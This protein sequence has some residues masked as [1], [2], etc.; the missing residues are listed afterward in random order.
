MKMKL[1]KPAKII[2]A[3]IIFMAAAQVIHTLSGFLAMS[4]YADPNYFLVWSKIMMPVA[5]AP[6][7]EFFYYSVLF[8]FITGLIYSYVYSKISS[9]FKVKS[10]V[11]KGIRYGFVLF[12]V[13]GIPAFLTMYL[14][15]NL[16]LELLITWT[17]VDTLFCYMVGGIVIAEIVR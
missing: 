10:F 8:A 1:S 14:M 2:L 11:Q 6:P 12:L 15:I 7:A 5:G 9:V 3:A 13:T 4:Y 16:P 17:I